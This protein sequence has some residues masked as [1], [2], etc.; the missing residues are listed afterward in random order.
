MT[1]AGVR[2]RRF[3]RNPLRLLD[4]KDERDQPYKE[5]APKLVDQL[6][7]AF[8]LGVTSCHA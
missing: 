8:T 7:R 6:S 3:D 4:S 2:Q 1:E 5:A